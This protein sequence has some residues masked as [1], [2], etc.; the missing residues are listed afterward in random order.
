MHPSSLVRHPRRGLTLVEVMVGFT[1]AG[2]AFAGIFALLL[3][4][5]RV[6]LHTRYLDEARS[7]LRSMAEQIMHPNADTALLVAT[8]TPTGAGLTWGS[9]TGAAAGL[10]VTIGAGGNL[11]ITALV[12]REVSELDE[13][14]AAPDSV[15]TAGAAGRLIQCRLTLNFTQGNRTTPMSLTLIR[16]VP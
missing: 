10:P 16:S 3:Q 14:S 5:Y 9:S 15:T 8:T 4:T 6:T 1:L 12:T 13:T 11:P 7:V 2:I